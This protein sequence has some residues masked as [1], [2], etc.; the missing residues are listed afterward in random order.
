MTVAK[1]T[2][3]PAKDIKPREVLSLA[4]VGCTDAEIAVLLDCGETT[5]KRRFGPALKRGRAEARVSLRREQF[6]LAL[7]GNAT[8]L[9]WLGKQLLG[10]KNEPHGDVSELVA[11]PS[12]VEMMARM[13]A[14]IPLRPPSN[15]GN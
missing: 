8:M 5:I 10:Q 7:A 14:S 11:P 3:R 6:R 12:M 1:K 4:T 15:N 9:I 13:D 2:G